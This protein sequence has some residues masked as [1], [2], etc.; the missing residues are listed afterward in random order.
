M[1]NRVFYSSEWP[2]LFSSRYVDSEVG[3]QTCGSVA[4]GNSCAF[5]WQETGTKIAIRGKGAVKEGKVK[6]FPLVIFVLL[7]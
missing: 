1:P 7:D 3:K 5:L 4:E 6:C 2:F